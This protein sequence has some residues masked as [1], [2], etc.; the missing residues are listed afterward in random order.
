MALFLAI[1]PLKMSFYGETTVL[2]ARDKEL[3]SAAAK[4]GFKAV[5]LGIETP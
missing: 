2:I 4:A 5:L 3:L 1:E